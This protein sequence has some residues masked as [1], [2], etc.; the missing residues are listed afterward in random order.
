MV[1]KIVKAAAQ[2]T[3]DNIM[4]AMV[5][6][7]L[8]QKA[9]SA[10][11]CAKTRSRKVLSKAKLISVHDVVNLRL[12]QEKREREIAKK[13]TCAAEKRA[14]AN[15][16]YFEKLH[17]QPKASK[18]KASRKPKKVVIDL[19]SEVHDS[20]ENSES[21][22]EEQKSSGAEVAP[23]ELEMED[24][25]VVAAPQITRSQSQAGP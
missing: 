4:L 5:N 11:D 3:A 2:A 13:K 1:E 25:I 7:T 21:Y 22:W 6:L 14:Q 17:M 15:K 18:K 20:D 12:D 24:V 19:D 16:K 10:V 8:H 9:T 23:S